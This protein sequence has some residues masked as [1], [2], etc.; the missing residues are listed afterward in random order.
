MKRIP[1]LLALVA[2]ACTAAQAAP[3]PISN[4]RIDAPSIARDIGSAG[5]L[6]LQ[7]QRLAKLYLQIGLGLNAETARRLLSK[8]HAQFDAD[9]SDLSRYARNAKTQRPLLR[10]GELWAELKAALANPYGAE[11]MK[12]VNYLSDDLMIAAG[13]LAMQIEDEA[14]TPV[15]RL[16]GLS[17][18]QS[19]LAQRL[20]KLYLLAQAGDRSSGRLVDVEQ[21]RKEFATTLAEL[22]SAR[23]N[24]PASRDALE[25]AKT[26]W[27]FFENEIREL[28]RGESSNPQHVATS[29]ERIVEVLDAVSA[30]YA[31]DYSAASNSG[32]RRN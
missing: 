3:A 16:L 29:S 10:T 13:K 12:R 8:G 21:A 17:L 30:H 14:E 32:T 11:N 26:Q 25:L 22:T 1:L 7:S 20:A 24:S 23:E 31:Q 15:G 6:R 5:R 9:L 18:R 4:S 27:L 2:L 28:S 19:M